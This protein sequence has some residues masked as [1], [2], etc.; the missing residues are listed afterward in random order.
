MKSRLRWGATL[1]GVAGL[2]GSVTAVGTTAAGASG[3]GLRAQTAGGGTPFGQAVYGAYANGDEVHLD[4]LTL[5]NTSLAAVDQALSGAS[6]GSAPLT[7]PVSDPEVHTVTTPAGLAAGTHAYANG[8]GLEVGLAT[9]AFTNV[10]DPN[11]IKLAGKAEQSAPP[12]GPTVIHELTAGNGP[13]NLGALG[14]VGLLAGTANALYD[15]M[16]CP[17]GEPLSF[18]NGQAA[19]VQ[20]LTLGSVP[21]VTT[22]GSG[23]SP[24]TAESTS[25]TYI[26]SNGNG[27]FGVTSQVSETVAPITV[28]IGTLATLTVSVQGASPNDPIILQAVTTGGPSG[29]KIQLLN[30]GVA[31]VTLTVAGGAP[32]TLVQIPLSDVT[33][34]GGN[35]VI[36]LNLA[37]L[38]SLV[39]SLGTVVN[40]TLT[41]VL[42]GL[43]GVLGNVLGGLTGTVGSVVTQVEG[44]LPAPV[45]NLLNIG[46]GSVEIDSVPHAIGGSGTSGGT[47]V[48]G[49]AASGAIDLLKVNLGLDAPALGLNLPAVNL[50]A[51]HMEAAAVDAQAI[52]CNIPITK[53]ASQD[54]VAAGGKFTYTI[55]VPDPAKLALLS[56]D[57]DNIT[58]VDTISDVKGTPTFNVLSAD[59]GGKVTAS[60]PTSATVTFTGLTYKVAPVGSPPNPPLQLHI[61][62]MVP[63]DTSAGTIQ[64]LVVASG[65]LGNCNGGISGIT[66]LGGGNGA[67]VNGSFSLQEPT[68]G[69]GSPPST[70]VPTTLGP[71]QKSGSNPGSGQVANGPSATLPLTG[72]PGGLWQPLAGTGALGLGL[73]SLALLR[74]SRRRLLR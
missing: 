38:G 55:Q 49:T 32:V 15:P 13:L 9:P 28:N 54:N 22:A 53:S 34:K 40:G 57:L 21:L 72:G 42:P 19:N 14:S 48:G 31:T 16:V 6:A 44:A 60:T 62:V 56:C 52:T 59:N 61:N 5:G 43:G 39:S 47:V 18:G 68:V 4:A 11:Q 71:G 23:G 66:N 65:D 69:A 3:H 20:L 29:A 41:G 10:T 58:V 67:I 46:L 51:G 70:E 12:N 2:V 63:L 26:S 74:R 36:P 30:G 37:Q 27:T 73:G 7:T 35:L 1:F 50:E 45:L 64:D 33:G 8:T 17:L 25:Q 24:A